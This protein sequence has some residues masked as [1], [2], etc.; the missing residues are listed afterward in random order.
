MTLNN[1]LRIIGVISILGWLSLFLMIMFID[2]FRMSLQVA[3]LFYCVVYISISTVLTLIIFFAYIKI[4]EAPIIMKE[5][6]TSMRQGLQFALLVP[7]VLIVSHLG[8]LTVINLLL[9]I[10]IFA[11]TEYL[12]TIYKQV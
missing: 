10:S 9:L 8:Y 12:I 7:T 11:T 4:K 3:L 2:P 6:K 5:L 1:Y